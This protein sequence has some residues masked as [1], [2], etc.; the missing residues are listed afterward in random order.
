MNIVVLNANFNFPEK[1]MASVKKFVDPL[2]IF[3]E[4]WLQFLSEL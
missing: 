2:I 3:L 1:N 4:V